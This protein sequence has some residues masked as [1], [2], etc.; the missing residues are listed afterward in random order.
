M[1]W[2]K[3]TSSCFGLIG[4]W[5]S[6]NIPFN[7]E[8]YNLSG[9]GVMWDRYGDDFSYDLCPRAKILRRDQ[10]KVSDLNS[11]KYMMRYNSKEQRNNPDI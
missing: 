10:A 8:I 3:N 9:Y 4:Y 7:A 1:V 11:L 6:Y 2:R 5:P